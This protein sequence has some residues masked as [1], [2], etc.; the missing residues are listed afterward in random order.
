MNT[1]FPKVKHKVIDSHLHFYDYK[2]EDGEYFFHCFED[3]RN[4]MGL[5]G[6]NLCALP[7][8]YGTDVTSN[9]MC[10]V[11][12]MLNKNDNY[13]PHIQETIVF[14]ELKTA[15]ELDKMKILKESACFEPVYISRKQTAIT[16]GRRFAKQ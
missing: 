5:A 1:E 6:I 7:S 13:F 11:Y 4:E 8:G 14:N 12:K 16:F 3:Y 15:R 9:I 10:A 2:S